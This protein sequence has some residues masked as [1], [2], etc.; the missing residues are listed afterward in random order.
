MRL[1]YE[2]YGN[3]GS[4]GRPAARLTA[5][6]TDS[7][8]NPMTGGSPSSS[9][10]ISARI[11]SN[12]TRS[13]A[14]YFR[15]SSAR[16]RRGDNAFDVQANTYHLD[17]DVVPC[18]EHRWYLRVPPDDRIGTSL[19]STFGLIVEKASRTAR[20]STTRNGCE[21]RR[22]SVP[23]SPECLANWGIPRP[24][25]HDSQTDKATERSCRPVVRDLSSDTAGQWSS[26]GATPVP[27]SPSRCISAWNRGVWRRDS[28][29]GMRG[30]KATNPDRCRAASSRH[31]M[32]ASSSPRCA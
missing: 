13:W 10:S 16:I 30:A 17:A 26:P 18:I 3:R 8:R 32:A 4:H 15:S 27:A 25:S 20:G 11:A 31:S 21:R 29:P 6:A 22:R 1:A 12:T 28:P 7:Y 24:P 9:G 2:R 19:V 5:G 14:S 23:A